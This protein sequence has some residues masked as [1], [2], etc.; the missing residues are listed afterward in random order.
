MPK[1]QPVFAAAGIS[2][3][4]T[5]DETAQENI[6]L[7]SL[8]RKLPEALRYNL[9]DCRTRNGVTSLMPSKDTETKSLRMWP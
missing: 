4:H 3:D 9:T 5:I 2:V 1:L 6:Y 8:R 7:S